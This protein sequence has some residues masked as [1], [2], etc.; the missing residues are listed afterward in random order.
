M[1]FDLKVMAPHF[2]ESRGELLATASLLLD[3]DAELF[4]RL[5][6]DASTRLVRPLPEGL[7]VGTY[8]DEG[9]RFTAE[10]R[11]G[12]RLTY[13]TPADLADLEDLVRFQADS[14]ARGSRCSQP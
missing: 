8:E 10:D 7:V 11:Y 13:T 3:R 12:R 5:A 6:P 4:A 14:C 1:G 2:R 9:L